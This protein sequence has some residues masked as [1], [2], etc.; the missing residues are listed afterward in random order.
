MSEQL[1]SYVA[2]QTDFTIVH[3]VQ[4]RDMEHARVKLAALHGDISNELIVAAFAD[5]TDDANL[6]LEQMNRAPRQKQLTR[7]TNGRAF[8]L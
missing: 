3:R 8:G 7:S 4:A 5:Y 1:K 2:Y 6:V